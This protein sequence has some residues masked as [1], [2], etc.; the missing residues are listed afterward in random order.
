MPEIWF[1]VLGPLEI[2]HPEAGRLPDGRVRQMLTALLVYAG[3]V[4]TVDTLTGLLWSQRLPATAGKAIQV[5]A[6]RLRRAFTD[7]PQIALR[8]VGS[9]YR[10]DVPA[11]TVDLW[12]FRADVQR[13]AA[14]PEA[15]VVLLDRAL[16]LWHGPA[17]VDLSGTGAGR[18]LGVAVEEERLRAREGR[19]DALLRGGG[20][21][22]VVAEL[23]P[24][25]A[26][27][28]LR[29]RLRGQLMVALYRCGRPTQALRVFD[30]GRRLASELGAD[31]GQ[32]LVE[33]RAAIRAG[34]LDQ[35]ATGQPGAPPVAARPPVAEPAGGVPG[36]AGR[37]SFALLGPFE[38]RLDGEVVALTGRQRSVLAVLLLDA[39]RVV[40]V[41]QLADAL[42]RD[43]P[44][45]APA[46]RIRALIAQLRAVLAA[47]GEDLI[48]TRTPG[49]LLRVGPGQVDLDEFDQQVELA[50]RA[51]RDGKPAE[52]IARYDQALACW[53]GTALAGVDGPFVADHIAR[54]GEQRLR[55]I[56]E[57]T[58]AML[59]VGRHAELVAELTRVVAE[60]P[61]REGPQAQ[62][63]TA[64]YRGG[65]RAEAL[66]V[67]R[68]LR[69]R[70]V[71]EL[72]LEP[73]AQLQRL[74]ARML[75][76]DPGLNQPDQPPADA[77]TQRVPQRVPARQLP[78]DAGWFVG[79][80]AEVARLDAVAAG[81]E[82][83]ALVVG[84]AGAGKT[85]LAL[86]WAR[87][88]AHRFPDG[89]LFIDMR[90]FHTGPKMA[91]AQALPL[92]LAALGH[93]PEQIPINLD[94]QAGLYR[95]TLAVRRLL[96]ILDNVADT[97]QVRPLIPGE[98]G[99][100]VLVTSRDRLSGLVAVDG[101]RRITLD[102]LPAA[103]ALDVLAHAAGRPRVDADPD[104]AAELARLCGHLPLALRIA[105]ARLADRPHL[106]VR[107]YVKELTARGPMTHLRVEG[108][109]TAT[110]RTAFDLSYQTLPPA[111]RRVFRLLGLIPAPAGLATTAATAL[112]GL[113]TDQIEPLI[114]TLAR[115]HL[116]NHTPDGRL[117][118]HDLL[119]QYATELAA[120]HDQPAER[121][122]AID[123]LL[124]FY[125]HATDRAAT[126]LI[127]QS[128]LRLPRDPMP[129]GASPVEF[130]DQTHARAWISIEWANLV[131]ALDAAAASGRHRTVW[132]L[133][134]AL[135]EFTQMQAPP[136]QGLRIAQTGLAAAQRAGDVRGEAAMR[137]SLG[138]LRWRTAEYH[139]VLDECQTATA[140]ARRAGWRK[141]ES[142]ALCNTG[143]ALAQLGKTR[144]AIRRFEQS[145]AID[146]E[147]GDRIG[148][149]TKLIN[150]TA[151]H[152]QVGDLS[153]AA[154]FCQLALPL[155]RETGQHQ[156][157]AIALENLAVIRREQGRLDEALHALDQSLT[158]SATIGDQHEQ[159]SALTTL[160]LV[161]RDAGRYDDATTALTTSI[162]IAQQTCDTRLES[163]AHTGLASVH[164]RQGH[165]E[166]AANSL[167]VALDITHKTG[168]HRGN[169]E[170]LLT[171]ADL[172]TARRDHHRAHE[173]AAQA[174]DLARTSGYAILAAQAHSRLAA[175][176]LGMDDLNGS[177]EHCRRALNTQRRAGQRL[178]HA[179]TLLTMGHAHQR[180]GH[181]RPAL[182]C[183]RQAHTI[184]DDIGA[185]E[186][187]DTAALLS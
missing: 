62:L 131:A 57:R 127:G 149:A 40:G 14:E 61:L 51:T 68:Q 115:L 29:E 170:T 21:D 98:P 42:W 63:M 23:T 112:C 6:S 86:H 142:A 66:A 162:D 64:L 165:I 73:A 54:L 59:T 93:K 103:D 69:G 107:V 11:E 19:V 141:G 12:R 37:L 106:D 108:D 145:L 128:R 119:L 147:I 126:V 143:I 92:L 136:V 186:R 7:V 22:R 38:V 111:A 175:A 50:G 164:I 58:E 99:C 56:E 169:V 5:H 118:C 46:A 176:S 130:V 160:G 100:L 174:L 117:I 105:G 75:A 9:G 137:L 97:D 41:G 16:G 91:A 84:A 134:N 179:R 177:L 150:L 157:H 178:A 60:H 90:G 3:Q 48:V 74:H 88:S 20:H 65:R 138:I 28:P 80:R 36:A 39:N 81:N 135:R 34:T 27:H 83:L 47:A 25:P 2:R 102:V 154:E 10:L 133:A 166:D 167:G 163:L 123:R 187:N 77:V 18:R 13:A 53:R 168:H 129:D 120:T 78:A 132:H 67:Y 24:L 171:L 116:V 153:T 8:R 43:S 55:A 45:A 76:G 49:Y 31:P 151:A 139:A 96:V 183:W 113:P 158:I 148:E 101:A 125:V 44:P 89:Q 72:G 180:L 124:H 110:V 95:S 172:H 71:E 4:V 144:P 114:D 82:R 15:A 52:A 104:A 159:A 152:E 109:D 87:R 122:T 121:D 185:P 181:T 17:L 30:E 70:L 182:T 35:A 140:L 155:Q 173:Q 161:H 146:R 32:H 184:F 26:D 79:H 1:R 85:A 156:G 33:L 94:A